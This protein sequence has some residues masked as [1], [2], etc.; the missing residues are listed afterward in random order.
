MQTIIMTVGTSLLT[1]RDEKLPEE[2]RRPWAINKSIFDLE[3]SIEWMEKADPEFISAETNTLHRLAYLGADDEII[4]LHSE[5][6]EGLK[7]ARAL[8]LFF[9]RDLGQRSVR[10]VIIPGIHY[11]VDEAGSALERM[12]KMLL[13][14][15]DKAK[16]DV[17]LAATGGFKAEVMVMA[18][19]GHLRGIPVCYVHEQ[20]RSLVYLPFLT[21]PYGQTSLPSRQAQLPASGTPRDSVVQV[22]E[23]PHH[24]PKVWPK[25][26]KMLVEIP[27]VDRVRYDEKAFGAPRNSVKASPRG[28]ADGRHVFWIRLEDNEHSKMAVSVESTGYTQTHV[29]QAAA[30]LRERLGRLL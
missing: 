10:L 12:S 30:E 14:L 8:E 15:V 17:T 16:G 27:W 18:V 21:P 3:K 1:N 28:T 6:D 11:E 9:T 26:E 23:V 7:C 24:R 2:K 25:V 5:T 22:S 4:L 29:E 20:Y 13:N 19:V